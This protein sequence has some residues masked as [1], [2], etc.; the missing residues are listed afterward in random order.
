ML[1]A[2]D[3]R[4]IAKKICAETREIH[5]PPVGYTRNAHPPMILEADCPESQVL[6]SSKHILSEEREG[7]RERDRDT[8]RD[9]DRDREREGGRTHA[10]RQTWKHGSAPGHE[11]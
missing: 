10:F 6:T 2:E 9:R 4:S 7:G 5:I 11:C 8:D 3:L 1:P